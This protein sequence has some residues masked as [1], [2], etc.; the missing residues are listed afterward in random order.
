MKK[1][2][3]RSL[4]PPPAGGWRSGQGRVTPSSELSVEERIRLLREAG[5][6]KTAERLERKK[7]KV[8]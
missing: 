4:A 1:Q 8:A 5:A 7:E 6:T 3:D 2:A